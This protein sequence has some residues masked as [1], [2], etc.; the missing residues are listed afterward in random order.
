MQILITLTSSQY[1]A[2]RTKCLPIGLDPAR[3][4]A[5]QL[6]VFL[7]AV[8]ASPELLTVAAEE[9]YDGETAGVEPAWS[10]YC[11]QRSQ[12]PCRVSLAVPGA[13]M[14]AA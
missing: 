12:P 10:R 5:Q 1:Q 3:L 6:L 4:A 11:R 13:A 7:E 8:E 14:V 9:L 2:V